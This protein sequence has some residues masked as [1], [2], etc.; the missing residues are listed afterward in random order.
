MAS[1]PLIA[2]KGII[3]PEKEEKSALNR[4]IEAIRIKGTPSMEAAV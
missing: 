4:Y 1:Y 2:K 3:S